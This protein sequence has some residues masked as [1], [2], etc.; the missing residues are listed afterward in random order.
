MSNSFTSSTATG[1][2]GTTGSGTNYEYGQTVSINATVGAGYTW[3]ENCTITFETD[4]T[5]EHSLLLD[6][7]CFEGYYDPSEVIF[8]DNTTGIESAFA[9]GV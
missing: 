7:G 4:P 3:G 6:S 2:T 8:P 5:R 1:I 9:G